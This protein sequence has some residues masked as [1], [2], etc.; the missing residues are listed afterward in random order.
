ME[1]AMRASGMK[2]E[3]HWKSVGA[4][5][6]KRGGSLADLDHVKTGKPVI[7]AW[8]IAGYQSSRRNHR[9]SRNRVADAHP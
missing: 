5:V 7:D 4:A 6:A 3:A 1:A 9:R 8:I 2:P